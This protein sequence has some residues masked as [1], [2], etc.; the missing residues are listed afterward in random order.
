MSH[1]RRSAERS[2]GC[3][4]CGGQAGQTGRIQDLQVTTIHLHVAVPLE[5]RE[6]PRDSL[7]REP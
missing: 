4:H 6:R 3:D 2:S 1:N 5:K 7:A